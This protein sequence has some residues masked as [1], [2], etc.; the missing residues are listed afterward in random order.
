MAS[1]Q[2]VIWPMDSHT[3]AKHEIL[4]RYIQAWLPIMT[5]Y[6]ERVLVI[7]GFAGPGEYKDGEIGSP[8]IITDAFLDHNYTQLRQKEVVFLFIEKEE[9]RCNHLRKLL[10]Q[11]MQRHEFPQK[12]SY[13]VFQGTFKD[14]LTD[15]LEYLEDRQLTMAPTFAF[16][17]PFGYSHTPISIIQG[18]MKHPK[19]EVLITFMYEE[20]NRFLTANYATKEQQ[21]NELFGTHEWQQIAKE[22]IRPLDRM[23]LLHDLYRDQL[24]NV[25]GA[26]HVR[27]FRMRNQHNATD[28]FLFFGT[29]SLKGL[30]SMKEAMCRIDPT[31][32]YEF[33]DFTNPYQ[34]LLFSQPNYSLLKQMLL[35]KFKGKI[36]TVE[37][38][39]YFVIA[40]TP[41]CKYKTEALKLMELSSSPEIQVVAVDSKRR[42]GTFADPNMYIKFL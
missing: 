32:T 33:S 30:K 39:E 22:A 7:D 1:P 3:H 26:T 31:G 4:R 27:S 25:A 42:R 28:Y 10:E 15:L 12:A 36:V 37:E 16:I 2:S 21:Y 20:I 6:N 9:K 11:R 29:K 38:V 34:L 14:A 17:D 23:R 5:K 41:F 40:E 24:V 18:L 8:L 19:C 35:D 13:H